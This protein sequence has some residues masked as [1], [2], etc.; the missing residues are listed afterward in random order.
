MTSVWQVFVHGLVCTDS[1]VVCCLRVIM[2]SAHGQLVQAQVRDNG[3]CLCLSLESGVPSL[4]SRLRQTPKRGQCCARGRAQRRDPEVELI[5]EGV[6]LERFEDGVNCNSELDFP[7]MS[8]K[9]RDS[10]TTEVK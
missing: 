5:A 3:C 8:D 1:R 10:A 6:S 9:K 7:N 4:N 2:Q